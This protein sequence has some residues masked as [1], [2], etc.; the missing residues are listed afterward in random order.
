MTFSEEMGDL[1]HLP[2]AR[3]VVPKSANA[4]RGQSWLR[5]PTAPG[6]R[7]FCLVEAGASLSLTL[8]LVTCCLGRGGQ[9]LCAVSLGPCVM[10]LRF[11]GRSLWKRW[12]ALGAALGGPGVTS[13]PVL[14]R[15]PNRPP[16]C[17][18]LCGACLGAHLACLHPCSY[19]AL[20]ARSDRSDPDSS[21]LVAGVL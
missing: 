7:L 4:A 11:V 9:V 12:V 16:G 8:C 19:G 15:E 5:S 13:L 17:R 2:Q 1:V 6:L 20:A 3:S 18:L 10:R 21:V 14:L